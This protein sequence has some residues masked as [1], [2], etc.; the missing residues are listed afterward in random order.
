MNTIALSQ[1]IQATKT[2]MY[3]FSKLIIYKWYIIISSLPVIPSSA[4]ADDS[5]AE[6]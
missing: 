6:E 3:Q 2:S 5:D 1:L 4:T